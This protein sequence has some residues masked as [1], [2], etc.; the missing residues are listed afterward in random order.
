MSDIVEAID[1]EFGQD[2]SEVGFAALGA[3]GGPGLEALSRY[4][5]EGSERTR[6]RAAAVLAASGAEAARAAV[7]RAL[8]D[9]SAP[10]RLAAA[11]ALAARDPAQPRLAA[12]LSDRKPEVRAEAVRLCG[13]HHPQRLQ[14]LLG[15]TAEGVSQAVFEVLTERPDLLP[16]DIVTAAARTTLRSADARS[17]A[18]AA[19][20]LAAVAPEAVFEDLAEQ[21]CDPARPLEVRLGA[22]KGLARLGGED[23]ANALAGALADD[24]RRLRLEAT[25]ALCTLARA[26]ATWPNRPGEI[27]LMALRGALVRAPEAAAEPEQSASAQDRATRDDEAAA[28]PDFPKS[29]LRS[30]LGEAAPPAAESLGFGPPVE[31]TREDLERL[32]LAARTPRK[33]VVPTTP[34]VAPHQDV[35]RFAARV[36]G[37]L[38]RPEV[39][40]ELA[41]ALDDADAELCRVAA[42]S[43]ARLAARLGVLPEEAVEA[44]LR[45]LLSAERGIRVAAVRGLGAAPGPGTA[46]V[47]RERLGDADGFV[48]AEALRALARL[49]AVGPEVAARLEDAEPGVR[50]AAAQ[51]VAGSGG[52][53]ALER[54]V[55]FAFAFEGY[56]RRQAGRML[57]TLDVAAANERFLGALED[58]DRMRLWP[59][60]IEALEELNRADV[61]APA[62]STARSN[63]EEGAEAS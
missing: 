11:R 51:A 60:A 32:A 34:Q 38:A 42:D 25:A 8:A 35:R 24:A 14:A 62:E 19:L 2:L 54:L 27:L 50:L 59:V 26:E 21:V 33:A 29:T 7:A 39:A 3:L 46:S 22:V 37:D 9:E 58:R 63:Q 15:D 61:P 53:G 1:D 20:A 16:R 18:S 6:R 12:L 47:L 10:V 5:A 41:R 28:E 56:H 36:L 23:A 57:R 31:L 40:G 48:R 44:L 49:G 4:L 43:L 30:I 52:A 13:Q 17:A 45:A 55:D